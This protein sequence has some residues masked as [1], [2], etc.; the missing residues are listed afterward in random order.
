MCLYY[1]GSKLAKR[2]KLYEVIQPGEKVLEIFQKKADLKDI[3][4]LV[5]DVK[6]VDSISEEIGV[7]HMH[8]GHKIGRDTMTNFVET[9][10]KL[11]KV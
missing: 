2:Q 5:V 3:K 1:K 4:D 8:C 10:L 11:G 7:A 6:G 9:Q